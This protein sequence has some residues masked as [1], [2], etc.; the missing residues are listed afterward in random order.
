MPR[1]V[2]RACV[3]QLALFDRLSGP[4]ASGFDLRDEDRYNFNFCSARGT[5]ENAG[6]LVAVGNP[7]VSTAALAYSLDPCFA[8]AFAAIFLHEQ[9]GGPQAMGGGLVVLAN[10]M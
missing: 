8:A 2:H 3:L 1:R 10:L 6:R 9:L 5:G 4:V 7:T